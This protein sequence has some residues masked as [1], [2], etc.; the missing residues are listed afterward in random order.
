MA[1]TYKSYDGVGLSYP[2]LNCAIVRDARPVI[3]KYHEMLHEIGHC[4]GIDSSCSDRCIMNEDNMM[5]ILADG[6]EYNCLGLMKDGLINKYKFRALA[7]LYPGMHGDGKVDIADLVQVA[8]RYGVD[9]FASLSEYYRIAD[10]D[11][12]NKIDIKDLSIVAKKFGYI[13][14]SP[15]NP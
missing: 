5:M 11:N 7:D 15:S 1:F 8:C 10:L 9:R 2:T 4:F 12:N 3:D 14:E 13:Y 6:F